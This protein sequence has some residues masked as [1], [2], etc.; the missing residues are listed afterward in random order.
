MQPLDVPGIALLSHGQSVQPSWSPPSPK[1]P[2][3]KTQPSSTTPLQSLSSPSPQL[4]SAGM[5]GSD[6][7]V[8]VASDRRGVRVARRAGAERERGVA[9]AVLIEVAVP[10]RAAERAELVGLAVAVVV[11]A[12]ADLD[13]ARTHGRVLVVAVAERGR[14]V[15]I[16]RLRNA[17]RVAG[18]PPAVAVGIAI[19]GRA[20][21]G[22]RRRQILRESGR[23][24]RQDE[25]ERGSSGHRSPLDAPERPLVPSRASLPKGTPAFSGRP[26]RVEF[27]S[28]RDSRV[29]ILSA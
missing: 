21:D 15:G 22:L 9:E 1:Q 18:D 2:W 28:N 5:H 20:A 27:G 25:H 29:P 24:A 16:G 11:E 4:S 23:G 8:A 10:G 19:E 26:R 12:V 13:R 7:V 6:R 14:G 3:S 17:E